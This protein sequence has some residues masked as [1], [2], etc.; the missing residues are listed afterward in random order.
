MHYTLGKEEK[1]VHFKMV[2]AKA[3]K[4]IVDLN[5]IVGLVEMQVF[6]DANQTEVNC[7]SFNAHRSTCEFTA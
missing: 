4:V 1:D 3:G 7:S 2:V 6:D 5:E